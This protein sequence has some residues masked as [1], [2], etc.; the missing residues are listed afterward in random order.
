MGSSETFKLKLDFLLC[1][2]V[3]QGFSHRESEQVNS[4]VLLLFYLIQIYEIILVYSNSNASEIYEVIT[5]V[6]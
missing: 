6:F 4:D 5:S 1:S 3:S 2:Y